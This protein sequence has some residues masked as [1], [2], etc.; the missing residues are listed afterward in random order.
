M[1]LFGRP[2]PLPNLVKKLQSTETSSADLDALLPRLI[3]HPDF[4]VEQ[5]AWML[6][7][8]QRRV[9][10]RALA[11]ATRRKEPAIGDWLVKELVGKNPE[12]RREIAEAAVAV[13]GKGMSRH[14]GRMIHSTT[15]AEREAAI[16]LI[17]V[18]T[19]LQDFVGY[20]KAALKDSESKIRQR[21]VKVLGTDPGNHT[22]F[23]ILRALIHDEDPII[24]HTVID[25]L[26]RKPDPEVIE[27]FFERVAHEEAEARFLITRALRTLARTGDTRVADRILPALGDEN[28]TIRELA[29]K[30]L[31]EMPD[32]TATLRTFMHHCQGLAFWL[33]ERSLESIRAVASDLTPSIIELL[34][35]EDENVRVG[36]MLLARGNQDPRIVGPVTKILRSPSDWW[37]RSMAVDILATVPHE[38]V[39]RILASLV[40]DP[41]LGYSVMAALGQH[42]GS[43]SIQVL[44]S[45]LDDPRPGIRLA[46]LQSLA[47]R[48]DAAVRVA[49]AQ[50][51]EEERDPRVRDALTEVLEKRGELQG[52]V[53]ARLSQSARAA[54]EL[55][56]ELEMENAELH[57]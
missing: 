34:G 36:A 39:T 12:T 11:E 22:I 52:A 20:L 46:A 35:D 2:D 9:R 8:P 32:V 23:M 53:A 49:L 40:D 51:A 17:A 37:V 25:A 42:P 16:D 18:H 13:G 48:K 44:T 41:E 38:D 26:A 50:R 47:A 57:V 55:P 14:L 21:A 15:V 5:H 7:H 3:E 56:L 27:P 1:S 43:T 54:D 10:E 30:M 6:S 31:S 29:V 24:R 28:P 19:H 4:K 45:K 33:R